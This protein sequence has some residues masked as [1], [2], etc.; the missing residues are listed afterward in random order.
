MLLHR[1]P[2]YSSLGSL[3]FIF[4]INNSIN[5]NEE[6]ITFFFIICLPLFTTIAIDNN[7]ID[8]LHSILL[9]N[10]IIRISDWLKYN[11]L[12]LNICKLNICKLKIHNVFINIKY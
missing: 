3:L 1:V 2:Q 9:L 10:T 11:K 4:Y 7:N 5:S 12:K 6:C 8:N